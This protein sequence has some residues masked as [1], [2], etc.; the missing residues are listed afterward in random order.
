MYE[1][2]PEG[3]ERHPSDELYLNLVGLGRVDRL[4]S[5]LAV[6]GRH[7]PDVARLAYDGQ[8]VA[9][10]TRRRVLA[11][12]AARR[13]RRVRRGEVPDGDGDVLAGRGADDPR[14]VD[15]SEPVV[16][17]SDAGDMTRRSGEGDRLE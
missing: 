14:T 1:K 11:H 15:G 13:R 12:V 4:L 17:R 16:L 8:L 9:A 3:L 2:A 7:A 10:G 5:R 6:A